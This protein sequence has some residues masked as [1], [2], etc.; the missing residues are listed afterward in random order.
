MARRLRGPQYFNVD[1]GLAKDF[2]LWRDKGLLLRFR[3]DAFNV[4]NHP[5][6]NQLNYADYS[7][8]IDITQPGNFGQLTEVNGQP[9]VVQLSGKIQF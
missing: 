7:G 5:N 3:A 8:Q 1:A 2:S 9:R 4:M 6:F